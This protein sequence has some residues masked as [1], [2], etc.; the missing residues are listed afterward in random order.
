MVFK[1]TFRSDGKRIYHSR[2]HL[3]VAFLL[4]SKTNTF[5][6]FEMGMH[7]MCEAWPT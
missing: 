5:A 7:F 3:T 2:A 4:V 1:E 6:L